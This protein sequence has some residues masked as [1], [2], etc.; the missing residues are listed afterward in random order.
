[1]VLDNADAVESKI[2]GM[3]GREIFYLFPL[4]TITDMSAYKNIDIVCS[5]SN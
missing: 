4:K 1:M 3:V 2:H 5:L